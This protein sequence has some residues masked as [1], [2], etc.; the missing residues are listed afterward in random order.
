MKESGERYSGNA[1]EEGLQGRHYDVIIIGGGPAGAAAAICLAR[2]GLRVMIAEKEELPRYKACGGGLTERAL[3]ILENLLSLEKMPPG[4]FWYGV[5]EPAGN[6]LPRR[7]SLH[8]KCSLDDGSTVFREHSP[9]ITA[10]VMR[11]VFDRFLVDRAVEEGADLLEGHRFVGCREIE[12]AARASPTGKSVSLPSDGAVE[13]IL[14]SPVS[15]REETGTDIGDVEKDRER[16]E[17]ITTAGKQHRGGVEYLERTCYSRLLIGCDGATSRVARSVGL[18]N[19]ARAGA[20]I[21]GEIWIGDEELAAR[22]DR[23]ELFF[24]FLPRGYCWTFPKPDHLSVGVFTTYP[25]LRWLKKYAQ[26]YVA[27]M[28]LAEEPVKARW[29]GHPI[30][31]FGYRERLN[32]KLV[33]L[34]GDAAGLTEPISGEGIS[35]AMQ[36][37]IIAAETGIDFLTGTSSSLDAYSKRI[38]SV[39]T[40]DWVWARLVSRAL[41]RHPRPVFRRLMVKDEIYEK[42]VRVVGGEMTYRAAVMKSIAR[43]YRLF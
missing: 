15:P 23:V 3:H 6:T 14:K 19:G 26:R 41:Y 42:F 21:E 10:M 24:G 5:Q 4:I 20:A 9:L 30:P 8:L 28:R 1:I 17:N 34:A 43:F 18:R 36:S 40:D 31:M 25:R 27:R 29:K 11:D 35:F 13:V 12:S 2:A 38:H 16:S 32:T 22:R 33:M 37:G 39:I 7:A